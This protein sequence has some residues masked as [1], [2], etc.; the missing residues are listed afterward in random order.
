MKLDLEP[1][2]PSKTGLRAQNMKTGSS[3]LG[4]VHN[5]FECAKHENETDTFDTAEN[6]S[7]SS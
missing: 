6:K 3:A 4:T 5:E 2:V 1:F 7:W